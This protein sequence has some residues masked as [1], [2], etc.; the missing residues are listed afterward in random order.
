MVSNGVKDHG[1]GKLAIA[2]HAAT[3]DIALEAEKNFSAQNYQSL[4]IVFSRARGASVW[5]PRAVIILTSTPLRLPSTMAIATRSSS[6]RWSTRPH[7]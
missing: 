2:H 6:L 4:T 7:D 5:D 1:P 3:T